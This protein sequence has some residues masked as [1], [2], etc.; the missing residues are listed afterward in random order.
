MTFCRTVCVVVCL[1]AGPA[2]TCSQS[3]DKV[4]PSLAHAYYHYFEP[5]RFEQSYDSLRAIAPADTAADARSL[6]LPATV[7]AMQFKLIE[8]RQKGLLEDT[9]SGLFVHVMAFGRATDK[10]LDSLEAVTF[11]EREYRK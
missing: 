1:V 4:S 11:S 9:D 6:I 8:W 2:V 10:Q 3:L 7:A 5:E